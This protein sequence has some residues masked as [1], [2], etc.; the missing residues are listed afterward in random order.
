MHRGMMALT[1]VAVLWHTIA[2]CCS[3][4]AHAHAAR[5]CEQAE[6]SHHCCCGH[7]SGD[8]AESPQQAR[9]HAAAI[10]AS[11]RPRSGETPAPAHCQG[12]ACVFAATLH[13]SLGLAQGGNLE[14][15]LAAADCSG[16]A[17]LLPGQF[18]AYADRVQPRTDAGP[19]RH[20]ALGV[21]LI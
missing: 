10:V 20:L 11:E 7:V 1:V 12:G 8:Q 21:L 4:H 5:S 17:G 19:R 13:T 9:D 3:H 18:R 2:G 6:H 14:T 16:E 15:P